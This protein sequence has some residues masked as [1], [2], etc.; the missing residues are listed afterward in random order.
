MAPSEIVAW[1]C[2]S[3]TYTNKGGE[4]GPCIMCKMEHPICYAIMA[5][6]PAAATT[7]TTTVNRCEQARVAASAA[8][9]A[10]AAV[11]A[12]MW[13]RLLLLHGL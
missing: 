2:G 10:E 5:G 7:R 4:P 11:T 6:A 3:C 8:S 9:A 1:E 13:G 12:Q